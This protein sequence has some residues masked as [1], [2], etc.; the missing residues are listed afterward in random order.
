M[1][2]VSVR[3]KRSRRALAPV[4]GSWAVA[5]DEPAYSEAPPPSAMVDA[6]G[7]STPS[8][9]HGRDRYVPPVHPHLTAE[10]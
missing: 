7:D 6:E 3:M 5:M 10:S 4:H 2:G 8:S 9:S 1:S